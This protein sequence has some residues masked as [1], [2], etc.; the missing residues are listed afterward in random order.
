MQ[1]LQE[2]INKVRELG[3]EVNKKGFM[4]CQFHTEN[5][6][7]A[8]LWFNSH[9]NQVEYHCFGCG[10]SYKFENFYKLITDEEYKQH[11]EAKR[12]PNTSRS[13]VHMS[14]DLLSSR[15]NAYFIALLDD[16]MYD[17]EF[18]RTITMAKAAAEYLEG[19]GLNNEDIERYEIGFVTR[20]E[21]VKME[22][23]NGAG[24]IKDSSRSCFLTF[25]VLNANG[26]VVSMQL[27]DFMNRGK[28]E[29]TKFNLRGSLPLW[30]SEP[31]TVESKEREE[32][33][34]TEGIHDAISM[35]K[36]GIKAI[37]MLGQP[38]K[39]Q[40]EELK[41]FK[42][43]TLALDNDKTGERF[44]RELSKELYPY[45]TMRK[46]NYPEGI[47]D[48]NELLQKQG[49]QDLARLADEAQE[50][51]LFPLYIESISEINQWNE[52]I[53][54]QAIPI[55]EEFEFLNEYLEDGIL[56][57]LYALA[58]TPGVG[59]TTMLNQLCD[60]LGKEEVSTFYLLSEEPAGRLA[61]RS[62][63]K[64]GLNS[65]I[66]LKK[67]QPKTLMYR[68]V[69]EMNPEYTA[70]DLED[71]MRGVK[72]RTRGNVPPVLVVDSLQAL[73]LDKDT[74]KFADARTKT[75]M[76]VEYLSNVAKNL[77]V[78][79]IFTSFMAR[80]YYKK[81]AT[82]PTMQVFKESG[83]IEYLIDVGLCLWTRLDEMQEDIQKVELYF[84]KNRFGK[85][86]NT[87]ITFMK[88]E[89]RFTVN[90]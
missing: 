61:Q 47:K 76:K 75:R 31:P 30:Y 26:D 7:S 48:P 83:D 52:R 11:A 87:P 42:H 85:C 80:E 43:L 70:R 50:V 60:A 45:S 3:I 64:E 20:A 6:P 23:F 56:P 49:V 15:L 33:I 14:L 65:I 55:P 58:G 37:A 36:A 38:S 72:L 32:W 81:D 89:C 73:R 79:V 8:R 66:E 18:A 88:R 46:V 90:Q 9:H 40:I 41:E 74:E 17:P 24:W 13:S 19:R 62:R 10:V 53:K 54:R 12:A 27:E 35:S 57:G 5:T 39:R 2:A 25:P 84:L 68:R 51:E 63:I 29:N 16:N 21:A 44:T 78:P 4:L 69:V 77:E 28:G 34:I 86:G 22:Q 1:N 67:Y 71:I 82:R 59:K